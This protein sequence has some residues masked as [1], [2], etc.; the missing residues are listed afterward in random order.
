MKL[1]LE[2]IRTFSGFHEIPVR[3]LTLLTGENS[4]GKSTFLGMLSAV[5]DAG[6][7][8]QPAFNQPPFEF[9]NYDTIATF[10]GGR[11]GRAASF[12]LGL[13]DELEPTKRKRFVAKYVNNRGQYRLKHFQLSAQNYSMSLEIEEVDD[14]QLR[15][16]YTVTVLDKTVSKDFALADRSL[17]ARVSP[18][19]Q[20]LFESLDRTDVEEESRR[21]VFGS[22]DYFS[23]L[24]S[25]KTISIAP[26]RTKPERTYSQ[27]Q[28]AY[29]PTGDHIPFLLEQLLRRDS[30]TRSKLLRTLKQFGDESGL[31]KSFQVRHLGDRATDPFQLLVTVAGRASNLVD[32]GYGVSQAL[33]VIV[34]A[35]LMEGDQTLLLQQPEVHLHP[36]AQAALGT[37]FA[38]LVA[39]GSSKFLVETHSDYIIDRVRQEAAKKTVPPEKVGIL[40]FHSKGIESDCAMLNL[41]ANG[42]IVNPPRD[43][44]DFFL[45][46]EV[47]LLT[48][49]ERSN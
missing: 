13:D 29:I 43:Y 25:T 6:F 21:I 5:C 19:L 47:N 37:F 34:Q 30:A 1:I 16:K 22:F 27:I 41:D 46:E 49:T 36:R 45:R 39:S 3:P 32:V 23:P 20:I 18:L 33:P 42:N 24:V 48:R 9:G 31:F 15:G 10:K 4:T 35:S 14:R 38:L 8:F 17:D 7:P 26:I 2:N 11:F 12:S 40:Y 28:E 44:R